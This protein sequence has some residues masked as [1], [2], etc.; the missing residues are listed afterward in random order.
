VIGY[1]HPPSAAD[2]WYLGVIG[3]DDIVSPSSEKR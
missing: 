3:A 2:L 1:R